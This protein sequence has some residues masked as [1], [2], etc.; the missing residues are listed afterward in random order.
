MISRDILELNNYIMTK[1]TKENKL[2]FDCEVGTE[3]EIV[4]NPL[5]GVSIELP[6]HAV[7]VYDRIIGAEMFGNYK[8]MQ[9]GL[10]WFIKYHAKEYMVLLD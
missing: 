7:A 3:S 6:P 1:A 8:K 10:D 9:Q 4:S 2:P 5:S